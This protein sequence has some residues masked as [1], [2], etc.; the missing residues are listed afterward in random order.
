M[1][2]KLVLIFCFLFP[3]TGYAFEVIQLREVDIEYRKYS[4]GGYNPLIQA[5]GLQDKQAD[6]YLGVSIN[7]DILHYF[8]FNN[9]VHGTSDRPVSYD[10]NGQFRAI[11]W[12][13]AL[14]LYVTD[15]LRVEYRHHSQHLLDHLGTNPF[16]VENSIGV[17]VKLYES[18]TSNGVIW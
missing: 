17:K 6:S 8:Y 1:K 9:L 15:F 18:K 3:V 10:G 7:T 11:G 16:P 13:Y 12:N 2:N 4:T 5:Y 14:G